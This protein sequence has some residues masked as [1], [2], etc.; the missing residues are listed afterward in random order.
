MMGG[1]SHTDKECSVKDEKKT[2][3]QKEEAVRE[4]QNQ[5]G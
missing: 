5:R 3:E 1:A 2:K 4:N